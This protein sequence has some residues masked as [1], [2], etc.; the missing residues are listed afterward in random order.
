[1]VGA[2]SV[3]DVLTDGPD[4]RRSDRRR[5][6]LRGRAADRGWCRPGQQFRGLSAPSVLAW[7]FTRLELRGSRTYGGPARCA[8]AARRAVS[9]LSRHVS[10]VKPCVWNFP[11]KRNTAAGICR[12]VLDGMLCRGDRPDGRSD[13]CRSLPR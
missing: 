3:E 12:P 1:M 6:D 8:N 4:A 5:Q 11:G 2:Y 7:D 9:F 10:L 13:E